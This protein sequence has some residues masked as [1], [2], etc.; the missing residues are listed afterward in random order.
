MTRNLRFF[1]NNKGL[2]KGNLGASGG[3]LNTVPK[4]SKKVHQNI[5]YKWQAKSEKIL[6]GKND[7][8]ITEKFSEGQLQ[9]YLKDSPIITRGKKPNQR[10]SK[11][12][13][14][15]PL[16]STTLLNGGVHQSRTVRTTKQNSTEKYFYSSFMRKCWILGVGLISQ[17]L[18]NIG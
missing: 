13:D 6:R 11:P 10:W 7:L 17:C 2:S 4:R 3:S 9:Q 18:K 1:P 5:T 12:C 8:D 16:N 14:R 15:N